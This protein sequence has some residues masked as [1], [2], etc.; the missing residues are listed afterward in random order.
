MDT[1]TVIGGA[2]VSAKVVEKVLG[3]T[4]E[5][6]GEG[7]ASFAKKRVENLQKIFAR[8]TTNSVTGLIRPE[9]FHLVYWQGF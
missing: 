5:Y 4:A 1:L 2:I 9:Q 7:V 3:P 6:I 8:L